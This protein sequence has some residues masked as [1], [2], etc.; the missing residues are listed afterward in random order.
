MP[1]LRALRAAWSVLTVGA[2]TDTRSAF[3][4]AG[5]LAPWLFHSLK[6]SIG[7]LKHAFHQACLPVSI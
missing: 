4:S 3:A 7:D 5:F 1:S 6:S 2:M